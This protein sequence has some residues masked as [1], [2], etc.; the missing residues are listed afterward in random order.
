MQRNNFLCTQLFLEK[1]KQ[2]KQD[3]SSITIEYIFLQTKIRYLIPPTINTHM[4]CLKKSN[5]VFGA[6]SK[7]QQGAL[8]VCC[9]GISV[10]AHNGVTTVRPC[11]EGWL[12]H[13]LLLHDYFLIA[14]MVFLFFTLDGKQSLGS[15]TSGLV[16][17]ECVH[18]CNAILIVPPC[19]E[20]WLLHFLLLHYYLLI[21]SHVFCFGI[22]PI[23][24]QWLAHILVD[25]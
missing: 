19:F 11:F 3:I 16:C 22:L 9:A 6:L 17:S 1:Q 7:Q 24:T 20:G 13:F 4:D 15:C 25:W 12:L 2:T 8:K 18:P 10:I 23:A 14:I 5:S 21:V